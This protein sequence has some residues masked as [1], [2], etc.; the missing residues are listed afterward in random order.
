MN[1]FARLADKAI[2]EIFLLTRD[3]TMFRLLYRRHADVLWRLAMRLAGGD[4]VVAADVTQDAWL[5]AIERLPQFRWQ[6]SLRTWLCGFVVMR[7]K[8]HWRV[9]MN[10]HHRFESLDAAGDFMEPLVVSAE[11]IDLESAL[12]L[13]PPGFRAIFTLHDLEGWKH[14]EI[15]KLL[16]IT[17]GTSKSQLSRA[18]EALRKM[19]REDV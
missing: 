10:L 12:P 9:E 15:A 19:L 13:L 2:V 7:V 16:G 4:R 17:V 3:E 8:E 14:E 18:R 5:R 11:K 6:S 1:P